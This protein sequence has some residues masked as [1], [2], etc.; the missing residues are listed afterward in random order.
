MIDICFLG[1]L[2]PHEIEKEIY[3]NSRWGICHA[4][5]N[6]QWGLIEGFEQNNANITV[7]TAPFLST[8]LRGYKKMNVPS[9][10]FGPKGKYKSIGYRNI[11]LLDNQIKKIQDSLEHWY[12]QSESEMKCILIYCLETTIMRAALHLKHK[13]NDIKLC[14]MVP[15]LPEDMAANLLYKILG[16]KKR[17]IVFIHKSMS[18][19]D[20]FIFLSKHMNDTLNHSNKPYLVSEGLYKDTGFFKEEN[21]L[22]RT[23]LY[24]GNLNR[25]YGIQHLVESFKKINGDYKLYVR[26]D[27][28]MVDYVHEESRYD[29]RIIYLSR[30]DYEELKKFQRRVSVL[31]NPV[32]P[33]E[34]FTNNFFPSKTME[35][36]ASGTPV[37]MYKLGGVPNEYYEYISVPDD[38]SEES[39]AMK[40]IEICNLSDTESRQCG[41]KSRDFILSRKSS[42]FMTK[43]IL[44]FI[45]K[46]INKL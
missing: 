9:C 15:D 37:V 40:I 16:F 27:G 33:T 43:D 23:I 14:Q 35:Y 26:G 28:D 38:L 36:L 8:Y 31:V 4:A 39:L 30:M 10:S 19:M 5:N 29:S 45:A 18:E 6:H 20:M 21:K 3:S 12:R 42:A 44:E 11:F 1:G 17:S 46:N 22:E 13:Y 34:T 41:K 7:I 24:T 25:K 32:L 2:Y